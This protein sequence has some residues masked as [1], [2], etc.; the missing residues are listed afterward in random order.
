MINNSVDNSTNDSVDNGINNAAG[1]SGLTKLLLIDDH[2]VVRDYFCKV[3]S[4]ENG[5]VITGE[6]TNASEATVECLRCQPD[7]VLMDVCTEGGASGLD[8]LELLRS[9]FP[10]LKIMVM[11]G[12]DE[13]AYAARARELGA[14]AFVFKSKSTEFF[15]ETARS[16]LQGG[17]YYPDMQPVP[18]PTGAQSPLSAQETDILRLLCEHKNHEEIAETLSLNKA[19]VQECVEAMFTKVGASST[20]ELMIHVIANGWLAPDD[21]E[22]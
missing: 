14:D 4:Q 9:R 16:V 8:S 11:S 15:L 20:V 3:F 13:I 22:S 7:L 10:A 18:P 2:Q 6:L 21:K 5:F 17:T 19:A 12:F 1:E